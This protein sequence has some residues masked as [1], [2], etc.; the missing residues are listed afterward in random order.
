MVFYR[1]F[2]SIDDNTENTSRVKV[3]EEDNNGK[4]AVYHRLYVYI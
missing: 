3:L 2:T 4:Y 1:T